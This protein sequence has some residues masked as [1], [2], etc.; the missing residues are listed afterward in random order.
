MW[1][2]N[3]DEAVVD[4]CAKRISG[5]SQDII[6]TIELNSVEAVD[7]ICISCWLRCPCCLQQ[8]MSR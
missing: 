7:D 2:D 6:F 4:S 8:A 5:S 1:V 3:H